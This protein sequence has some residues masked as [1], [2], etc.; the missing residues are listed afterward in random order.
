MRIKAAVTYSTD[1]PYKIEEIEL[2]EPK[3]GEIL[4]RIAASGICHTDEA[5]QHQFIPT[6][7]PAVLGHEGAGIVE[8]VGLGVTEFKP[9]DRVAISS[10]VTSRYGMCSWTVYQESPVVHP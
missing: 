4:V 8:K 7:L 1:A 5:V 6:P 3:I 10:T 9:G 2:D